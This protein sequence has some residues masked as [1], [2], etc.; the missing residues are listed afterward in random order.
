M[1]KTGA[2]RYCGQVISLDAE[3]KTQDEKDE[4]ASMLC[5]CPTSVA[6][7]QEQARRTHQI[8]E[9]KLAIDEIITD[10]TPGT[11]PLDDKCQEIAIDILK[12]AVE[13]VVDFDITSLVLKP[14]GDVTVSLKIM[15]SGKVSVESSDVAKLKM[16]N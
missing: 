13:P 6:K 9:T 15:G 4:A 16:E 2:C 8:A 1:E 14:P 5:S 7:A 10:V 12:R 3:Y 11:N